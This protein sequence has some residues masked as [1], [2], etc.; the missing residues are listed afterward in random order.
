M[1]VPG[2]FSIQHCGY[3]EVQ[4]A[5]RQFAGAVNLN[6][7]LTSVFQS[8][9]PR[10]PQPSDILTSQLSFERHV[11]V[12]NQAKYQIP[13]LVKERSK[14]LKK[15][16]ADCLKHQSEIIEQ[17]LLNASDPEERQDLQSLQDFSKELPGTKRVWFK[18]LTN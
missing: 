16:H 2:G 1:V 17:R 5:L 14:E 6:P 11:D 13:T 9:L 4:I 12:Y 8:D 18:N 10:S 7:I 3:Y 15:L